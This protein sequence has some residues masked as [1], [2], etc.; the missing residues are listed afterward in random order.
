MHK[1]QLTL[2]CPGADSTDRTNRTN[3]DILLSLRVS[4][5]RRF[6]DG[7]R[8]WRVRNDVTSCEMHIVCVGCRLLV[9]NHLIGNRYGQGG[10]RLRSNQVISDILSYGGCKGYA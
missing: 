7:L 9:A 3:R 4:L 6:R 8:G 2:C 5:S 1:L 10:D